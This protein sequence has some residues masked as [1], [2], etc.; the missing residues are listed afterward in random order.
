[1]KRRP[2]IFLI[3]LLTLVFFVGQV[4][5]A[6][7]SS[8]QSP[9]AKPASKEKIPPAVL[10][11]S[12]YEPA[13]AVY[14]Q[15]QGVGNAINGQYG[16]AVRIIPFGDAVGRLLACKLGKAQFA[17]SAVDWHLAF[18]GL[19]DFAELGWGPQP[20]ELVWHKKPTALVTMATTKDSGIVTPYDVKG[21][22]VAYIAGSPALNLAIEA[23]LAFGNLTTKDVKLLNFSGHVPAIYG[24]MK[25]EVD[26]DFGYGTVTQFREA[27][28]GPKGLFW[29]RLPHSDTEG[30]ARLWK[31]APYL[32]QF[33][34]TSELSAIGS[35]PENPIQGSTHVSP[36]TVS[37]QGAVS[38]ELAYFYI[39][40]I[41]ELYPKYKDSYN[42]LVFWKVRE[43]LLPR[44]FAPYHPGVVKY[45]K[46][47]GIWNANY[48][49]FQDGMLKRRQLLQETWDK[50]LAEGM[51]AGLTS[52]KVKENWLKNREAVLAA[53]QPTHPMTW[54]KP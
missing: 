53:Q 39:K 46:E 9:K 26:I 42:E 48:Q 34:A 30:W 50:T 44:G 33:P 10:T 23:W 17:T 1:M 29:V 7:P 40:A 21:K 41:D 35:S 47:K 37:Y 51:Q 18:E 36:V 49:K 52:A 25:G 5:C 24:L 22:R 11:F 13:T 32:E 4:N 8:V 15:I 31:V 14:S 38:D 3:L 45:L 16:T 54:W 6:T 43:C 2:C 28:A 12:G 19:Y 20:L 27:A